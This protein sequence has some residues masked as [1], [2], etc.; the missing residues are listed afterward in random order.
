MKCR[1]CEPLVSEW[2]DGD[3][4]EARAAEVA[5]HVEN[6]AS[7]ARAKAE[8][9]ALVDAAR[10]I[11]REE[12]ADPPSALWTRISAELDSPSSAPRRLRWLAPSLAGLALAA[13]LAF[14]L[15]LRRAPPPSDDALLTDA[16][17]EFRKAESHYLAAISDL[18]AIAARDRDGWPE[19]RRHRYDEALA[20][21][22]AAAEKCR[23]AARARPT[24]PDAQDLL[25]G[26]Y[27]RQ[28]AFLEES[29]LR[30]A[31]V[32]P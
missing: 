21:L 29:L 9:L 14:G 10:G 3:L 7:C 30:G 23:G 28:V 31:A 26:A 22:D 6:C 1:D 5:A 20:A 12:T 19:A 15:A 2:I 16:Q 13:A 25:Y 18:R 27:R 11:G 24:D 4:D 8:L 17:A 32:D